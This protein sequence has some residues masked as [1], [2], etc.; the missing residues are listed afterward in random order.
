MTDH[1]RGTADLIAVLEAESQ[2]IA[3]PQELVDRARA[4]ATR[5][6]ATPRRRQWRALVAVA[7]S[8]LLV[9]AVALTLTVWRPG[10]HH[11]S[12]ATVTTPNPVP[13]S[14]KTITFNGVQLAIPATWP[15][16]DGAHAA[17]SC[18]STFLRQADRAF[19]GASMQPAPSCAVSN[20]SPPANGVWLQPGGS[21]PPPQTP[22]TLPGG[23]K[24]YLSTDT[25]AS[26]VTV[27][28]RDVSIQI[29][30][31]ADPGVERAILDSITYSSDTATSAVLGRCPAVENSPAMPTPVRLAAPLTLAD[32]SGVMEPEPAYSEPRVSAATVWNSFVRG[33]G[34]NLGGALRWSIIFGSYS[35]QTP[36]QINPDGS[37][38]PEYHDVPTWLIQAKAA[39]TAYG[40]CGITVFAPYN[41]DTGQ[42]MGQ[43]TLG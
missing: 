11:A 37:T 27:W 43:T 42:S 1:T 22:R 30:I 26:A 6:E 36:A 25:R 41:A 17:Y 5:A 28:Y 15:V 14:T 16:I 7:A 10:Q 24:V 21:T 4:A 13:A 39:Q 2:D 18:S 9:V 40:P 31:G 38:T 8:V 23:Q 12:P 33:S 35:A 3:S 34:T 20:T 19:L 32:D 29:G